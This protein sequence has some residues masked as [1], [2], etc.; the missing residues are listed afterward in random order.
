MKVVAQAQ[1]HKQIEYRGRTYTARNGIFDLPE[2]A[3]KRAVRLEV[4]QV[5]ALNGPTHS[6]FGYH[7]PACNFASYFKT[8]SRC[9]GDCQRAE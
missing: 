4:G 5:P 3:A 8:C 6:G 1:N 7:C 2:G 9:A